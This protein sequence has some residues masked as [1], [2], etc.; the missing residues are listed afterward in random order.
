MSQPISTIMDLCMVAY[1][2]EE[3][4]DVFY[5]D[6]NPL[7]KDLLIT[8]TIMVPALLIV[9]NKIHYMSTGRSIFRLDGRLV[10]DKESPFGI[11]LV[12]GGLSENKEQPDELPSIKLA[13]LGY[14]V[15]IMVSYFCAAAR[16]FK[17]LMESETPERFNKLH[18]TWNT[19]LF[20]N[21]AE[22]QEI[23]LKQT[24]N[25]PLITAFYQ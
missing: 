2:T 24:E 19:D 12:S 1:N 14:S 21:V 17:P 10:R 15:G 20:G 11:A 13:N 7:P 9:A 8:N 18:T 25:L 5:A 16:L 4:P 23:T 6:G 3:L 22:G